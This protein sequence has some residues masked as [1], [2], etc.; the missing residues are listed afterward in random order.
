[1]CEYGRSLVLYRLYVL[2]GT[3]TIASDQ[4]FNALQVHSQNCSHPDTWPHQPN[5]NLR[6]MQHTAQAAP[7]SYGPRR[8]DAASC[9]PQSPCG[10][11]ACTSASCTCR[12][13]SCS[14]GRCRAWR[15]QSTTSGLRA[16]CAPSCAPS[17]HLD[18]VHRHCNTTPLVRR[19]GRARSTACST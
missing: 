4:I 17:R 7:S 3:Y 9:R 19:A 8:Q 1:M 16:S 5:P 11:S 12:T 18:G 14:A 10:S 2:Y 13:P 6:G 15:P